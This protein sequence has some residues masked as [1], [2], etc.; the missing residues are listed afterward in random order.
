MLG[1]AGVPDQGVTSVVLNLTASCS[2]GDTTLIAYPTGRTSARPVAGVPAGVTRS[3]L[4]T[5]R[6]GADGTVS[7]ANA[8]GVTELTVDVVGYYAPS[9]TP[10]LPVPGTRILR[11]EFTGSRTVDLPAT[12]GGISSSQIS[13]V[14][15]DVSVIHPSGSGTLVA[16]P[17][18]LPTLSYRSGESIDNQ[19]VVPVS[20]GRVVVRNSGPAA[21]VVLD[22]HG[23]VTAQANG[24]V[25]ALKPVLA[26]DTTLLQGVPKKVTVAGGQNQVPADA[27]AVLITLSADRP[28]EA[29]ALDAYPW[30]GGPTRS[31]VL[32]AGRGTARA[33]QAL[34]P[35]GEGGA[36]TLLNAVGQVRVRVDVVGY[37]RSVPDGADPVPGR[38]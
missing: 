1:R 34:V 25:T 16:G 3:V 4:V 18:Q 9:G 12:V 33:N 35:V 32:R 19:A 28:A 14:V 7:V 22:L 2:T 38:V 15:L 13:A 10:V 6:V 37:V 24:R 21:Q 27:S 8:R 26:T 17:G 23:V 5:T 20:G 30:G 11:E 36:I 31:S 29:T